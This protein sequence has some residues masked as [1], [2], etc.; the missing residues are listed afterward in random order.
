[1]IVATTFNPV[2]HRVPTAADTLGFASKTFTYNIK[3]FRGMNGEI[4]EAAF[5][6]SITDPMAALVKGYRYHRNPRNRR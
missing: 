5:D 2:R 1:M 3:Q 6:S 4:L